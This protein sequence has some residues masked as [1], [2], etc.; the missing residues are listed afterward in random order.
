MTPVQRT[1]FRTLYAFCKING[2]KH[3]YMII[4][5]ELLTKRSGPSNICIDDIKLLVCKHFNISVDQ[6]DSKNRKR[7]IVKPRQIAHFLSRESSEYFKLNWSLSYIANEI[8]GKDHA[9]VLHSC[10]TVRNLCDTERRFN[11][12]V[13]SIRDNIRIKFHR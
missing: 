9:T 5:K 10:K 12:D 3:E 4:A 1:V 2:F 7:E 13:I 11:M 8:G 6:L